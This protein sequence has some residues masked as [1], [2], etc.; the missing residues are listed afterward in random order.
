[1]GEK[2]AAIVMRR[3]RWGGWPGLFAS[4]LVCFG[5]GGGS[6]LGRECWAQSHS[7]PKRA[8]K[9]VQ[10]PAAS[11]HDQKQK[12][13]SPGSEAKRFVLVLPWESVTGEKSPS[14]AEGFFTR[15]LDNKDWAPGGRTAGWIRWQMEQTLREVEQLQ[16]SPAP[17]SVPTALRYLR[18]AASYRSKLPEGQTGEERE[19]ARLWSQLGQKAEGMREFAFALEA[20]QQSLRH[21][22]E[23][24][25]RAGEALTLSYLGRLHRA[26]GEKEPSRQAY[27]QARLILQLS[28]ILQ[29]RGLGAARL[30]QQA[31]ML[32]HL[33][34]LAEEQ[35]EFRQ[36]GQ[37]FEDAYLRWREADDRRG[38]AEGLNALGSLTARVGQQQEA[39]AFF[40]RALP[41][42]RGVG[43][44]RG[45]AITLSNLGLVLERAGKPQGALEAYRDSLLHWRAIGDAGGER[46]ALRQ[47]TR[48]YVEAGRRDLALGSYLDL[49]IRATPRESP[50]AQAE[51]LGQSPVDWSLPIRTIF[52]R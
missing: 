36:A 47:L 22:R 10:R 42:W 20:F 16:N 50:A 30:I 6:E 48:I 25:D 18:Q 23:A 45:V 39:E 7:R 43:D 33:G 46:I 13:E 8:P 41:L 38:Q 4:L 19:L 24:G 2:S 21:S 14:R 28:G 37:Y 15:V 5:I 1:M 29:D 32:F 51:I 12:S 9:R 11:V 44:Q 31:A 26:R 52:A 27:Q 3:R 35:Q 17:E 40:Q 49:L 34:K